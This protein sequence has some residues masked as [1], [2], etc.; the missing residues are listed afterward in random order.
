MGEWGISMY[1]GGIDIGT[2]SLCCVVVEADGGRLVRTVARANDSG[3]V[4][5]RSWE[6]LQDPARIVELAQQLLRDCGEVWEGVKAVGISCQMH[7]IVYIDR[8]GEAVSPLF[9]LAGRPGGS[10]A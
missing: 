4:S 8:E 2:T 6:K 9:Y 5:P 1:L 10:E 3:I 7:G